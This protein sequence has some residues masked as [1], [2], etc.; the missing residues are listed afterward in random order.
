MR[1]SQDNSAAGLAATGSRVFWRPG[2]DPRS[3]DLE[4]LVFHISPDEAWALP[5]RHLIALDKPKPNKL[6]FY[7]TSHVFVVEAEQADTLL[8]AILAGSV[9]SLGGP[10]DTDA[11][12]STAGAPW[13]VKEIVGEVMKEY[14]QTHP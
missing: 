6:R 13:R 11:P 12:P 14:A 5:R 10:T 3:Y 8:E 2:G 4:C 7:F 9:S 1:L